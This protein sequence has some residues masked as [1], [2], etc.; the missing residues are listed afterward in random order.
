MISRSFERASSDSRRSCPNGV[1]LE[2]RR[3]PFQTV[4]VSEFVFFGFTGVWMVSNLPQKTVSSLKPKK[5]G[6]FSQT[7]CVFAGFRLETTNLVITH[8]SKECWKKGNKRPLF[9]PQLVLSP[10]KTCVFQPKS[11]CLVSEGICFLVQGRI[12]CV[13]KGF[14]CVRRKIFNHFYTALRPMCLLNSKWSIASFSLYRSSGLFYCSHLNL[15][16][17]P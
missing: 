11:A 7:P 12:V 13:F 8:A 10:Q 1:C 15:L 16:L 5:T 14:L 3:Q 4:L 17:A 2:F 6:K 9:P